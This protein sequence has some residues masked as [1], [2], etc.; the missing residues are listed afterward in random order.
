VARYRLYIRFSL[1]R[2]T[3]KSRQDAGD[4]SIEAGD[5]LDIVEETNKDW[6]TCRFNGRQGILPAS[7]VEKIQ[8]PA[9]TNGRPVYKPFRAAYHGVDQPP[10]AVPT[11]QPQTN[12]LGLQEAPGQEEKKSKYGDLK[13]TVRF[14]LSN[15]NFESLK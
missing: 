10:A 11:P 6:W 15:L 8:A 12:S 9:A 5:V 2:W 1:S 7:Y 14:M 13:N 3:D 4:L